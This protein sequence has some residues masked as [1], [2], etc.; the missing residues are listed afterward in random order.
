LRGLFF[1]G[2]KE[3]LWRLLFIFTGPLRIVLIQSNTSFQ[4]VYVFNVALW[5]KAQHRLQKIVVQHSQH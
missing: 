5:L 1:D 3:P 2:F 4:P